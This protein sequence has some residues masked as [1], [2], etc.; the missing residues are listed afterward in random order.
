MM[1]RGYAERLVANHIPEENVLNTDFLIIVRFFLALRICYMLV[2]DC[3]NIQYR[4]LL[5]M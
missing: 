3:L 2:Q 4:C 5:K 1:T